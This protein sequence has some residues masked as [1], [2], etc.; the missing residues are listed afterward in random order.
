[1]SAEFKLSFSK[2]FLAHYSQI[3]EFKGDFDDSSSRG[4]LASLSVQLFTIPEVCKSLLSSSG[5]NILA[6]I[7]DAFWALVAPFYE[8][9]TGRFGFREIRSGLDASIWRVIH[10]LG[11]CFHHESVC[12]FFLKDENLILKL[13][14]SIEVLQH[15]NIQTVKTGEHVLY[16]NVVWRTSFRLELL[17]MS[18]LASLFEFARSNGPAS[19]FVSLIAR[20]MEHHNFDLF[21]LAGEKA[22]FHSPLSR[23][24]SK[25]VSLESLISDSPRTTWIKE[26]FSLKFIRQLLLESLRPLLLTAEIAQDVWVRNGDA[27]RFQ[28]DEYRAFLDTD[29]TGVFLSIILLEKLGFDAMTEF[30]RCLVLLIADIPDDTTNETTVLSDRLAYFSDCGKFGPDQIDDWWQLFLRDVIIGGNGNATDKRRRRAAFVFLIETFCGLTTDSC[31]V[32]LSQLASKSVDT[33]TRIGLITRCLVQ[34]MPNQRLSYS[35]VLNLLP[36]PLRQREYLLDQVL[37][38]I[39]VRERSGDAG[40]SSLLYKL[41]SEGL[42][43][44]DISHRTFSG[45]VVENQGM[46]EFALKNTFILGSYDDEKDA[47]SEFVRGALLSKHGL[48]L[49]MMSS[50]FRVRLCEQY[51]P[52]CLVASDSPQAETPP[53]Q[54]DGVLQVCLKII[55][56][57]KREKAVSIFSESDN[58]WSRP[59][60]ALKMQL[61]GLLQRTDLNGLSGIYFGTQEGRLCV[62]MVDNGKLLAKESNTCRL[63]GPEVFSYAVSLLSLME[64]LAALPRQEFSEL[65]SKAVKILIKR[66]S[67]CTGLE[68]DRNV[69]SAS[70]RDGEGKTRALETRQRQEL[71]MSRMKQKQS[72]FSRGVGISEQPQE[73]SDE[74]AMCREARSN[75]PIVAIGYCAAGNAIARTSPSGVCIASPASP[76]I[77]ACLHTVHLSCWKKHCDSSSLRTQRGEVF[78]LRQDSGEVQCPVCRTLANIAIPIVPGDTVSDEIFEA[79]VEFGE[80]ILGIAKEHSEPRFGVGDLWLSSSRKS[81]R[82]IIFSPA[83]DALAEAA[84]NELLL[85]ISLSPSRVLSASSLHVLLVRCLRASFRNSCNRD[86]GAWSWGEFWDRASYQIDCARLF[87]ES[88]CYENRDFV[89]NLM[90]LR[91]MQLGSAGDFYD[92]QMAHL[93]VFIAWVVLAV[94]PSF[95]PADINR[96]GYLPEDPRARLAVVEQLLDIADW[97]NMLI[98]HVESIRSMPHATGGLV[99]FIKLPEKLTDLIGMTI[100]RNCDKCKTQPQDPAICLLCGTLVCLD[101]D[102]CRGPEGEG[103][104][105][106]HAETCGAGQGVFILPYA[107]IVVAVASPRNC[108]W[109]G[110]YEDSHGEPDS[111]MKRTCKLTLSQHRLDQMRLFYTRGSIPIEI[112]KQNQITGRYVPRQL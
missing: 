45:F 103:E 39:T 79:V 24:V 76:Y 25:S 89:K 7:L 105:T 19:L 42:K 27:M 51:C 15:A 53:T 59:P 74:C 63:R 34:R 64:D 49:R 2:S 32:Q 26:V 81:P 14:R 92:A 67:E 41:N 86:G 80:S 112:V 88:T 111:Y 17:F 46:E 18:S 73:T 13:L 38:R 21:Q 16:E 35:Q 60:F 82:P 65:N 3:V 10:D 1:M 66:F 78:L 94:S 97:R 31:S 28:L 52:H 83:S 4:D 110:P 84:F 22:S 77:N 55:D 62:S 108:I 30:M 99:E 91:H 20:R 6:T 12:T 44:F 104:C 87:L 96:I 71:L 40:G 37:E 57:V 102:C 9:A 11:Y 93:A 43:L 107:S 29:L 47:V 109:E 100:N 70:P 50:L 54:L 98:G 90:A 8:P 101:S 56:N 106:K 61:Q 85:S 68:S 75:D 72:K 5:G 95:T 48:L 23:M 58:L 69:R 33:E 36:S